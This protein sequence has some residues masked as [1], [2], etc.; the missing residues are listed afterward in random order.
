MN[1]TQWLVTFFVICCTAMVAA[2]REKSY[3]I[4]TDQEIQMLSFMMEGEYSSEAQALKDTS[5]F[6]I[7][8]AMK[9]IWHSRT[10]AIWLYVEQ[11]MA[12]NVNKPYRQR[13]YK[14]SRVDGMI[15]SA[16]YTLT[17]A[18]A[19]VGAHKDSTRAEMIQMDSLSLRRGCQVYLTYNRG[20][21]FGSTNGTACSSDINSASYATSEVQVWGDRIVSWDRGFSATGDQVWGATKGGYHFI[22]KK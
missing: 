18:A 13:V 5:Y 6:S 9:R 4:A 22:K 21:F 15:E 3:S 10:D 8:L 20:M 19:V 12:K 17:N 7:T 14:I 11:A 1:K 16:V 2:S